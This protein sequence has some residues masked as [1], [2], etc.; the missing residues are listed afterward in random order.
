MLIVAAAFMLFILMGM[1][2]AFAIGISGAL[3]FLQNPDLPFYIPVQV[4]SRIRRILRFW[5]FRC[6]L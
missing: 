6:S 3:F 2:V 1:P 4:T 5:R